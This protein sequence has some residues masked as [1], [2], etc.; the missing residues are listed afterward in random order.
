MLLKEKVYLWGL[1]V[2]EIYPDRNLIVFQD[3]GI[4]GTMRIDEYEFLL[5]GALLLLDRHR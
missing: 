2:C 5:K 3:E 4:E 1:G